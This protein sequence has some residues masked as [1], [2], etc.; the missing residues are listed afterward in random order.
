M[1]YLPQ[2]TAQDNR[3]RITFPQQSQL[4]SYS[5]PVGLRMSN[6]SSRYIWS[7]GAIASSNNVN[8]AG[9]R[10]CGHPPALWLEE[11][12]GSEMSNTSSRDIWSGGG[13]SAPTLAK[14][15]PRCL[16]MASSMGGSWELSLEIE[17]LCN[18]LASTA[19][20]LQMHCNVLGCTAKHIQSLF[21][22]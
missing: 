12:F 13:I 17:M 7:G 8:Y 16:L 6:T 22:V 4:K 3:L 15:E 9:Q 19:K 18:T 1:G 2:H 11:Q 20:H 5:A 21:K 10:G 14:E